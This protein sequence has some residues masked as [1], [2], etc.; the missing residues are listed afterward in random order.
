MQRQ[1]VPEDD[2]LQLQEEPNEEGLEEWGDGSVVYHES[3][4][5]WIMYDPED[6]IVDR[7]DWR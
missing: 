7:E 2:G 4:G 6:D 1:P 3:E 5:T